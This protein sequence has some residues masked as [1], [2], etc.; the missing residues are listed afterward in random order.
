MDLCCGF[1]VKERFNGIPQ[2]PES[3]TRIDD[4]HAVQGLPRS[5]QFTPNHTYYVIAKEKL[6]LLRI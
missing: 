6:L 1:R 2:H 3:R 5:Q 4:E